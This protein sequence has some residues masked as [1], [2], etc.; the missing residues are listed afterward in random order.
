MNRSGFVYQF[1]RYS[2]FSDTTIAFV[3]ECMATD[4][5]PGLLQRSSTTFAL[6]ASSAAEG[7]AMCPAE[8]CEVAPVEPDGDEDVILLV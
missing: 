3:G 2:L 4:E 5:T 7:V 8:S 1:P 6:T